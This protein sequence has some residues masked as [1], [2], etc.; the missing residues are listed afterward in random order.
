MMCVCFGNVAKSFTFI[1]LPF[2]RKCGKGLGSK[3]R[4]VICRSSTV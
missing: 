3:L 2:F 1:S 4:M